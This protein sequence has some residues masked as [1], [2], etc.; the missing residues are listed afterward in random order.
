[1]QRAANA[2]AWSSRHASAFAYPIELPLAYILYATFQLGVAPQ[3]ISRSGAFAVLAALLAMALFTALTRDPHRAAVATAMLY[4]AVFC[5]NAPILLALWAPIAI[6]L[7]ALDH[8]RNRRVSWNR[9]N[10]I[11]STFATVLLIVIL[12]NA[13][14]QGALA[15]AVDGLRQ[16]GGLPAADYSTPI[17]PAKPD[18]YVVV[19]DGYARPDTLEA[20]FGYD[21]GPFLAQLRSRG[22]DVALD[23]HS[24]YTMTALTLA[25]MLN[26]DYVAD[27]TELAAVGPDDPAYQGPYCHAINDNRVFSFLRGQGYEIVATGSGIEPVALRQADVYLDGGEYNSFEWLMAR[28]SGAR[29]LI[30]D[31]APDWVADQM[32]SRVDTSLAE[33][34]QIAQTASPRPRL[35]MSHVMFSH[36]PFVYGPNGEHLD[37]S[38]SVGFDFDWPNAAG[39]TK[40]HGKYVGQVQYA[41]A[42]VLTVVDSILGAARRPTVVVLM[43]DHGSRMFTPAGSE[44]MSPEAN[45][46]FFA[47]LTP[48][49]P[50]LFGQSPSP[51]NLFR[52]LF[53]AYLGQ[54]LST[55]ENRYWVS[56][57]EHPNDVI[58]QTEP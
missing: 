36:P 56:S 33:V 25:S 18:I 57:W 49:H 27:I 7:I 35:V 30:Q 39:N 11:I 19:L 24:N 21:D 15:R 22:F 23:S 6:A 46:N 16:G 9:V 37:V 13:A 48:E 44:W 43:S 3:A 45:R 4:V 2:L 40:A 50:N 29:W 31:I 53:D 12:A 10:G 58:P 32:R 42:H 52:L 28:V 17:D 5:L 38:A 51:V 8:L 47:A 26:M 34:Q 55:L 54:S 41:N 1:M 20:S 14:A